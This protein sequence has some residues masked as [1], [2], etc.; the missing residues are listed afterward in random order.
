M[1][2]VPRA[3]HAVGGTRERTP[4]ESE[5]ERVRAVTVTRHVRLIEIVGSHHNFTSRNDSRRLQGSQ[6]TVR[7]RC[8]SGGTHIGARR[9]PNTCAPDLQTWAENAM[10][11]SAGPHQAMPSLF[12]GEQRR[13]AAHDA[14]ACA[15]YGLSRH[16]LTQLDGVVD[17]SSL[18]ACGSRTISAVP[19]PMRARHAVGRGAY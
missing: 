8:T 1:R 7:R 17:G 14:G 15:T 19:R 10:R 9:Q 6:A 16:C 12:L 11:A 4:R 18:R 2:A 5:S 13:D 3:R